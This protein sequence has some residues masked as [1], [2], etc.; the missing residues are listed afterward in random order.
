MFSVL[1]YVKNLENILEIILTKSNHFNTML[2][3]REFSKSF[4]ANFYNYLDDL[5][6]NLEKYRATQ[7]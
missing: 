2:L 7:F 1:N 3:T 4:H 6:L 5:N